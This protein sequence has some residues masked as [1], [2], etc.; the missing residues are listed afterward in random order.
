[1][2]RTASPGELPMGLVR[3]EKGEEVE[4]VIWSESAHDMCT[5]TVWCGP[6]EGETFKCH[7]SELSPIGGE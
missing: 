3:W 5:V 2:N 7:D 4:L 1:M 6:K